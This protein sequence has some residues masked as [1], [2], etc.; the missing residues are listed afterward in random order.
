MTVPP[1]LRYLAANRLLT[2]D[3]PETDAD[4]VVDL[5]HAALIVRWPRLRGWLRER[6]AA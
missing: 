2:L 3:G 4:T 6:R 1:L 5:A